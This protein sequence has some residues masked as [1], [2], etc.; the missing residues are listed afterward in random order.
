MHTSYSNSITGQTT[1]TQ[2]S[3]VSITLKFEIIEDFEFEDWE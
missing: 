2:K 1:L 3:E